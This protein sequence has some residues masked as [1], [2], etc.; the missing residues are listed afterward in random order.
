MKPGTDGNRVTFHDDGERIFAAKA[1][2]IESARERVWLETFLFTPDVTGRATLGMLADAARRGCDVILLFDQL[3]SH[4]T[5]LGFFKPVENAG[6]RVAIFNPLP[7]W[8]GYGRSLGKWFRYRNHRKTLVADDTAFCGGHNFSQS[9]MGPGPHYF[10]DVS[11]QLEGPSVR[12]VGALFNGSYR[13]VTGDALRL[14]GPPAP[15]PGGVPVEVLAFDGTR[16]VN[17]IADAFTAMLNGAREEVTMIFAYFVPDARLCAPI[18][19]AAR[20]GVRVRLLTIGRT[21]LRTVRW[22]GQ[23]TYEPLLEAGVRIFQLQEPHLH[24]KCMTVDGRT[25]LVGSFDVNTLQRSHTAESAVRVDDPGLARR[26]EGAFEDR[27]AD[28]AEI[29]PRRWHRRS[30]LIRAVEWAAWH[31]M[32]K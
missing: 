19:A 22:A 13:K 23:Y 12:D 21:D 17:G 14:P 15:V 3:G 11:V 18:I 4:V 5:N 25:S 9:Y 2:A 28:A 6:G 7:P 29:L 16:D 10:Y 8:R 32:A 1:E 27:L 31:A 24:A 20:R 30:P 26:I